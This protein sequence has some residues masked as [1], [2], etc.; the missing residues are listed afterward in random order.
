[1]DGALFD[2][3]AQSLERHTGWSELEARGTLRI[4]IKSGGLDPKSIRA[5]ELNVVIR[6]LM[7]AELE[8]R[9]VSDTAAVCAAVITDIASAPAIATSSRS[10][11]PDDVF[12][13]L[14][15]R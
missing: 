5:N 3:A 15:K 12:R 8:K 10:K 4:A 6:E 14:A 2:L 7:P 9:G 13:R 1:M 11:N